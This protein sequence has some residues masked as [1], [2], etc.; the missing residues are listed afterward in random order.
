LVSEGDISELGASE[1]VKKGIKGKNCARSG[2]GRWVLMHDCREKNERK[3][4]LKTETNNALH[5]KE[6]MPGRGM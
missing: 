4:L 2:G 6:T 1:K 5:D 3:P